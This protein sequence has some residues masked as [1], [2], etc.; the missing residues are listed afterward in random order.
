MTRDHLN[1]PAFKRMQAAIFNG[2]VGT[3]VI[4]KLDRLGGGL[5]GGINTLC[6]WIEKGLR[7]VST[8]QQLD[9]NGTVGKMIAAVLLGI[10]ELEQETRRERQAAGIAVARK[11]GKYMGRKVGT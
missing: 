9:F 8:T 6:G 4:W 2:E 5:I 7:V 11:Q 10:A 1:R 3:V